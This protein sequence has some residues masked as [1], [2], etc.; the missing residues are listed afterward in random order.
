ML[1]EKALRQRYHLYIWG[2]ADS[3]GRRLRGR[4]VSSYTRYKDLVA[5]AERRAVAAGYPK[6]RWMDLFDWN[7]D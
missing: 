2:R 4:L 7:L 3:T 6:S 1:R 5:D